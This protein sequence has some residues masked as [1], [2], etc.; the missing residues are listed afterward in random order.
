VAKLTYPQ[1]RG[2]I[3]GIL[4][5]DNQA[6]Q[7]LGQRF[8]RCLSL[9]PGPSGPDGG[10]DG[11]GKDDK[12]REIHFQCKLLSKKLGLDEERKYHSD[13]ITHQPAISMMLAEVGYASTFGKRLKEI[14]QVKIH[15]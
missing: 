14:A 11:R 7:E 8:A 15:W 2:I 9:E 12:G 6:K 3:D 13:I 5:A 10:I 1:L 4:S